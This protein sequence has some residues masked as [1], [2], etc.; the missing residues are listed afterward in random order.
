MLRE[1]ANNRSLTYEALPEP[2]IPGI[3][4]AVTEA[5]IAVAKW[6][7]LAGA[8]SVGSSS[9]SE[10]GSLSGMTSRAPPILPDPPNSK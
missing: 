7:A 1:F 8:L 3:G 5:R 6:S 2:E 9:E 10:I 4:D